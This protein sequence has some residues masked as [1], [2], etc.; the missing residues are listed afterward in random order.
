MG[1]IFFRPK[2]KTLVTEQ[3]RA[4]LQLKH[5]R[6]RL[7]QYTKRI[8]RQLERELLVAKR[9]ISSGKKEKALL[10]LRKKRCLEKLLDQAG[11]HLTTIEQLV[12]DIEFAQIQVD[13][14]D[15]LKV[16]NQALK[17]IHQIMS[18]EDVERIMED[19]RESQL[20]QKEIDDII[21]GSMTPTDTQAAEAE[22][23]ELL[24]SLEERIPS[25]PDH[26]IDDI[27]QREREK[28]IGRRHPARTAVG[29]S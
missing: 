28:I 10:L 1:S 29:A 6:D 22:L 18:L 9:L 3:D 14:M 4:V 7:A 26:E 5:Q 16:G 13:V 15:K 27:T 21:S 23:E 25:V 8:E 20:Y 2:R 17:E 19:S 24:L 12:Q 11:H